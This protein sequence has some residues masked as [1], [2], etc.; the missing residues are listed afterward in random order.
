MVDYGVYG[1]EYWIVLEAGKIDLLAW[2]HQHTV[3]INHDS[4]HIDRKNK[5]MQDGTVT[6]YPLEGNN[7]GGK[8]VQSNDDHA[9]EEG[10]I[11]DDV[12]DNLNHV[13]PKHRKK[14]LSNKKEIID[15][16][17]YKMKMKMKTKCHH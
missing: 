8:L 9:D 6:H 15:E 12:T 7:N 16:N 17:K 11:I 1:M 4:T 13:P 3:E 14:T 10:S 5:K 2:R